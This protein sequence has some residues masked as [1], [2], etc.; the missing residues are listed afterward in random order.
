MAPA[1]MKALEIIA[2]G[3]KQPDGQ[4]GS[5][6]AVSDNGEGE[7][8]PAQCEGMSPRRRIGYPLPGH[9]RKQYERHADQRGFQHAAGAHETQVDAQAAMQ[10][11][12]LRPT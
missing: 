5:R 11:E 8:K 4:G 6:E 10:W 1:L 3:Q 7:S 12:S 9:Y 2:R